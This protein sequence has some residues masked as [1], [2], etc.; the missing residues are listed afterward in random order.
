MGKKTLVIHREF[1][2]DMEYSGRYLL[3]KLS[4]KKNVSILAA[5]WF[6]HRESEQWQFVLVD[7]DLSEHGSAYLY[8]MISEFNR[9]SIS[10]QYGSIPLEN[11]TVQSVNSYFYQNLKGLFR[12]E[13]GGVRISNSMFNG[14]DI[15]DCY[16]YKFL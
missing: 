11:I 3:S 9:S 7:K 12:I 13:N 10:K 8:R 2:K 15:Y 1:T 16:I 14:F 5:L 6:L 4:K